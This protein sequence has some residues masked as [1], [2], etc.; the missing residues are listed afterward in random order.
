MGR[1]QAH[2]YVGDLLPVVGRPGND[3]GTRCTCSRYREQKN[4]LHAGQR[5]EV[6]FATIREADGN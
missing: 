5:P 4:R 2:N 1:K 6:H 3:G